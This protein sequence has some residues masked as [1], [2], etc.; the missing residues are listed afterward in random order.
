MFEMVSAKNGVSGARKY[1]L[2]PSRVVHACHR[3]REAMKARANAA[4]LLSGTVI[5]DETWIGGKPRN[6]H[7][8]KRNAQDHYGR[9]NKTAVL[10]LVHKESGEVRSKV[11]R[12]FGRNARGHRR[13]RWTCP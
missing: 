7:A 3:I 11:V 13:P 8:R 9:D 5:A 4:G 12:T 6:Q 2:T 10:S 1:D